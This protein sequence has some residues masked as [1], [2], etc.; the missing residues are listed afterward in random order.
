M[1]K[2]LQNARTNKELTQKQVAQHVGMTP[3]A[4]QAIE[5][6]TRGTSES[7]WIK[8]YELFGGEIPLNKLMENTPKERSVI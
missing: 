2:Q 1:R 5:L 8:L 4:Y 6:G 3:N 7:N